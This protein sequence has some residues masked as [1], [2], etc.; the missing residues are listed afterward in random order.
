MSTQYTI[1]ITK[2]AGAA[3]EGFIDHNRLEQ[4]GSATGITLTQ[5]QAK[6]RSNFRALYVLQSIATMA[7]PITVSRT[8]TGASATAESAEY[9][10]V[11]KF[12]SD[13]SLRIIRDE[14]ELTGPLAIK[15]LVAEALTEPRTH[16]CDVFHPD[17]INQIAE[18]AVAPLAASI[19]S[20][21]L[22][23]TV[24]TS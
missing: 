14:S 6:K 19:A 8:A 16:M 12:D 22:L 15:Q 10:I 7:N 24:S 11:I 18:L 17:S 20:A 4:Y 3:A 1:T 5:A 21:K 13:A 23:V 9:Q 2:P